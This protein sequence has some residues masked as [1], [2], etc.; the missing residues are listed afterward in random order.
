MINNYPTALKQVLKNEGGWADHP[1]DPGGATMKGITIGTYRQWKNNPNIT[2]EQLRAISD[3]EVYD[4]YRQQYWNKI[5][6][7]YLPSGV[8]YAVFD[9]AV[10][11]GVGRATKLIQ[12]AVGVTAD[13]VLGPKSLSAIQ[14]ANPKELIE[15]FSALK[16]AFYRSLKTFP[17][18]GVG[19]LRRV[20]EVKT[21]SGSMIG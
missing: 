11:M 18:F 4:I 21:I 7:D 12:E 3:A 14:K 2:K 17:V 9:A 19:W 1:S 5:D 15:K 20:A 10:N 8:D 6:G 13:G 16:E